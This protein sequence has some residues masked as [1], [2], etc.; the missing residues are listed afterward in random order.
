MITSKK[1]RNAISEKT[2]QCVDEVFFAPD[3]DIGPVGIVATYHSFKDDDDYSCFDAIVTEEE[4]NF[5]HIEP[6][7]L[8]EET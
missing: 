8:Y 5:F 7:Q 2:G 1:F 6:W 4:I 3:V